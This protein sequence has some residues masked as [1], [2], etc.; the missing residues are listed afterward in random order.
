MRGDTE[1]G[2]GECVEWVWACW[3]REGARW[4]T[5]L[6]PPLHAV[7]IQRGTRCPEPTRGLN[8]FRGLGL[9]IARHG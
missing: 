3:M 8:G 7:S 4:C 6:V 9:R 1:G 5:H 2:G